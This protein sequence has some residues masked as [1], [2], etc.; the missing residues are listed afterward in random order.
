MENEFEIMKRKNVNLQKLNERFEN[1]M[2]DMKKFALKLEN[3][4]YE[5]KSKT[6]RS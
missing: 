2:E 6:Q 5:K 4:Y 3:A 1:R